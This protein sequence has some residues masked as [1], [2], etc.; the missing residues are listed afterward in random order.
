MDGPTW[1][2]VYGIFG[3]V[4]DETRFCAD[5][6]EKDSA[7]QEILDLYK[8]SEDWQDWQIYVTPHYCN[9]DSDDE[10][11]CPQYM[12]DHHPV[13]KSGGES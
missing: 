11:V 9:P 6:T 4:D 5:E 7:V 8:Q 10:C 12:T 2:D 13:H 3:G 1:Y